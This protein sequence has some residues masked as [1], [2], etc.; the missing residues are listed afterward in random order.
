[1][2]PHR[3]SFFLVTKHKK[4]GDKEKQIFSE[5]AKF[6]LFGGQIYILE[7]SREGPHLCYLSRA[8]CARLAHF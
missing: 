1:M 2:S 7:I 6:S 4:R 5:K 3:T 8:S